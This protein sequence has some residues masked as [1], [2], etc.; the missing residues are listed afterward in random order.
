MKRGEVVGRGAMS[1]DMNYSASLMAPPPPKYL[2][3]KTFILCFHNSLTTGK[4]LGVDIFSRDGVT[5]ERIEITLG[6]YEMDR[7]NVEGIF[8]AFCHGLE[9]AELSIHDC[10]P[11]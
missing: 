6:T 5:M 10:S 3:E 2:A 7:E 11:I 9:R 8:A 4:H 1:V